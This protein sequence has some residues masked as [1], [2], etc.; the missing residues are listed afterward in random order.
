MIQHICIKASTHI[1]QF[2]LRLCND[3]M[4]WVKLIVYTCMYVYMISFDILLV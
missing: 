4:R 2:S 1:I 3:P